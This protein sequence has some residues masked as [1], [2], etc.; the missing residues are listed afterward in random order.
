MRARA[1]VTCAGLL[2]GATG[3][4]FV[5]SNEWWIRVLDFPR[6]QIAVALA[7]VLAACVLLVH[8]GRWRTIL[9]AGLALALVAQLARI[10]P[11]TSLVEPEV[12]TADACGEEARI[13]VFLANVEYANRD[14]RDLL[15]MLAAT[16]PDVVLLTEPGAWWQ[17]QLTALARDR[18]YT[19]LQ[20]Q[21]DTWGMLLYSRFPLLQPRVRFPV[22]QDIPS[23]S[24]Q[25]RLPSGD[26][27]QFYGV[28][29]RPP[30]PGDD[31]GD[32][33]TELT[34]IAREIR[35]QRPVILAGDL[36]DVAWSRTSRQLQQTAALRDPRVGRGFFATFN[37]NLPA[38]LRWPLDHD[39][40]LCGLE[41]PGDINSD[42]FPLL[43]DLQLQRE[44]SHP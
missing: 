23:I 11:Y 39:F 33:D 32:R 21:E 6:L 28:H 35:G 2:I 41:R 12:A 4:S 19:V 18:P 13:R 22:E 38:G 40:A 34:L 16:D 43:V 29:P 20:P 27:V 24:A 42:H 8:R 10:V 36:N 1:V 37:A 9:S 17:D 25:I 3:V 14:S 30:R 26:H 44:G 31:T 15:A 5:P 7:V